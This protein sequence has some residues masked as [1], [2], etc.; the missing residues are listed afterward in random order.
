MAFGGLRK[1]L[2]ALT[3]AEPFEYQLS[4]DIDGHGRALSL[5]FANTPSTGARMPLGEK[6]P[7]DPYLELSVRV[8]A[9]RSDI[10][11][12]V[13]ASTLLDKHVD[14]DGMSLNFRNIHITTKPRVNVYIDNARLG[15][16]PLDIRADVGALRVVVP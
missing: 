1:H 16:T 12:R 14:E 15:R 11:G 3:G 8:G 6:R 4:G 10:V 9:T 7:V 13:L 2:G 5:V